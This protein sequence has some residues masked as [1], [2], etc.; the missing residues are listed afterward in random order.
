MQRGSD[1]SNYLYDRSATRAAIHQVGLGPRGQKF[2]ASW[3]SAWQ[4]NQLPSP[5]GFSPERLRKLKHLLLVCAV[6][7]DASARVTFAG[8]ELVRISGIKLVGMDWFSLVSAKDLPERLQRTG[9]V[10]EGALLRTIRE[11]KLNQGRKYTFEMI[12]APLR[13]E[14]DGTVHVATFCDWN[15][16]D[17]KAVLLNAKELAAV[18]TL[19]EFIPVVRAGEFSKLAGR[20]LK[21]EQRVKV[22]SQAAVRF[23]MTF[24]REA[25]KSHSFASLD[26]TDYL[27]AITIDSQNIAHMESD[28]NISFRYAGLIEPDWMRRGISRAA[29]SRATHIP[30]ETVRRRINQ[31]I[32]KGILME[33][34]DGIIV[35]SNPQADL[36]PRAANMRLN[37]QLVERFIAELRQRGI[38]FR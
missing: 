17:K 3:L 8:Q 7:P 29:V 5:A 10:A 38:I 26:P 21:D 4:G 34:K 36:A 27:I 13:A 12:S 32:E 37:A 35:S 14:E 23:V 33:R 22:I 2:I 30:L 28:P 31:L 25:L 11:V 24:M 19:A 20:E 16:P 9:A 15:P 18:P 6:R 1:L